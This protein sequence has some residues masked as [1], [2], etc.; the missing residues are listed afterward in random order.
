[1]K[2][3]LLQPR[4][5]CRFEKRKHLFRCLG[6]KSIWACKLLIA[7]LTSGSIG[8]SESEIWDVNSASDQNIS[9]NCLALITKE[10][11]SPPPSLFSLNVLHIKCSDR[12][13]PHAIESCTAYHCRLPCL[14]FCFGHFSSSVGNSNVLLELFEKKVLQ[15]FSVKC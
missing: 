6:D 2:L 12:K 5:T 7:C 14:S 4:I 15:K 10:K 13:T 8:F 3:I 11:S 9:F 1:M